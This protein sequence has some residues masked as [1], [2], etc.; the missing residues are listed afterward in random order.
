MGCLL[1]HVFCGRSACDCQGF[2]MDR[3]KSVILHWNAW[4]Q[5]RSHTSFFFLCSSSF[6]LSE[7]QGSQSKNPYNTSIS[8]WL[9][10]AACFFASPLCD[11]TPVVCQ[12]EGRRCLMRPLFFF[13]QTS[14]AFIFI[15]FLNEAHPLSAATQLFSASDGSVG[16]GAYHSFLSLIFSP[17]LSLSLLH[18]HT[19]SISP[20]FL[21]HNTSIHPGHC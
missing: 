5:T 18:A 16:V 11:V 10:F 2:K 13:F 21:H 7:S 20:Y 19:F 14:L 9:F 6:F 17:S 8:V 3:N 15:L 4:R 1:F 12:T